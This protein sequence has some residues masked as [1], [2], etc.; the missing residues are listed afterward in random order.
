[1]LYYLAH[2]LNPDL[3]EVIVIYMIWQNDIPVKYADSIAIYCLGKNESPADI[4]PAPEGNTHPKSS[5]TSF[6]SRIKTGA[7]SFIVSILQKLNLKQHVK[8][9]IPTMNNNTPT[10]AINKAAY[11]A[12][13]LLSISIGTNMPD[14][15]NMKQIL[16]NLQKDAILIP[17]QEEPTV[18]VWLSQIY[19]SYKYISYLCAPESMHLPLIYP[20]KDR[21]PIENWLFA[22]AERS[23]SAVVVPNNWMHNDMINE[24]GVDRDRVK[25]LHNPV[26][27]EVILQKKS[28]PL[29]KMFPIPN[30]KTIFVQLARVDPQKNHMLLIQACKILRS[31]YNDFLVLVIG[32]GSEYDKI[33]EEIRRNGLTNNIHM[34]GEL[35]NPYPY[36]GLARASL[37]TSEFEASPLVLVDSMLCGA[38]PIATDCICG[39]SDMLGDNECGLLVEPGNAQA[40][41]DAM[42]RIATDGSLHQRLKEKGLQEAWRYDIKSVVIEWEKLITQTAK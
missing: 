31:K 14:V 8:S 5:Q 9:L 19:S 11:D 27:C 22:N 2:N 3:F 41:A 6:R 4:A 1:M 40:F 12:S 38:V 16:K 21:L 25:I 35:A 18:R 37:L 23:A 17:M 10:P 26:D 7:Y 42:Y 13:A 34:L 39:P 20:D 28:Q 32:N 24:F 29:P 36:L 33:N 15:I 30:N